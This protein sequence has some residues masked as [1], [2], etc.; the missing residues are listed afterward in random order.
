[1]TLTLDNRS[2]IAF[3]VGKPLAR[4]SMMA[5]VVERAHHHWATVALHRPERG[6]PLPEWIFESDLIIQRGLS[7]DELVEVAHVETSGVRCINRVSAAIACADRWSLISRLRTGDVPV[8]RT[9]IAGTWTETISATF[10]NPVVIKT[11]DGGTGRGANVLI[12]PD[13]QLP[14]DEPFAGPFIV[15]DYLAGNPTVSKVYVAGEN[16][17]GLI[18]KSLSVDEI[19][20][21]YI[22]PFEV[23]AELRAL[24][25]CVADVLSLDIFGMDV[26]DGPL[27]PTV[28]DVNPFPGFR[29]IPDASRLIADHVLDVFRSGV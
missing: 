11:V 3:L 14:A 19:D 6:T 2:K 16:M 15:Q 23:N 29:G 1:M 7:T 9:Y 21:G 27:G 22:V 28:I 26:L 25:T 10:G 8:P 18:K 24:A 17:R 13:G 12:A 5:G 4:G 20:D